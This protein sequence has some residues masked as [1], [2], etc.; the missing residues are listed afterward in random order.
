M[1]SCDCKKSFWYLHDSEFRCRFAIVRN[2]PGIYM[3]QIQLGNLASRGRVALARQIGHKWGEKV[4]LSCGCKKSSWYLHD[5][6]FRDEFSRKMIA[7]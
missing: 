6:G 5:A 1:Q 7:P 2:L 3:T 4:A